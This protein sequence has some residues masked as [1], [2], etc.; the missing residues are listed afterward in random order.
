MVWKPVCLVQMHDFVG[1][2]AG[3]RKECGGIWTI[4][5][6]G[7][8][9]VQMGERSG[10][11]ECEGCVIDMSRFSHLLGCRLKGVVATFDLEVLHSLTSCLFHFASKKNHGLGGPI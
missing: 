7:N 10:R 5:F 11:I 4:L 6:G 8:V 3:G 9:A 1:G 2:K